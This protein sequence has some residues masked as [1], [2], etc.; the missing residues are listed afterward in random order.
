MLVKNPPEEERGHHQAAEGS[1]TPAASSSLYL[2]RPPGGT[3]T[4]VTDGGDVI[5][6]QKRRSSMFRQD[7]DLTSLEKVRRGGVKGHASTQ[8]R[9]RALTSDPQNKARACG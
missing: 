1:L 3:R 5:R 8:E 6:L 9:K 4:A 2:K 7:K